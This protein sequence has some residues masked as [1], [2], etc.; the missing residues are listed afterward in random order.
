MGILV[1][2]DGLL[3]DIS[4]AEEVLALIW[5][6]MHETNISLLSFDM[7]HDLAGG[8]ALFYGVDD[9]FLSVHWSSI[10]VLRV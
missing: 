3:P 1:A 10:T 5:P 7:P 4:F 2:F 9:D 8:R 6:L